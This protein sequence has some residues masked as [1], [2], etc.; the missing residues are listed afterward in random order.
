MIINILLLF[1]CV[2]AIYVGEEDCEDSCILDE[3][4]DYGY[5][6]ST[7]ITITQNFILSGVCF[8]TCFKSVNTIIFQPP[9]TPKPYTI[10]FYGMT[11]FPENIRNGMLKF[12]DNVNVKFNLYGDST[13]EMP[14]FEDV[15]NLRIGHNVSLTLFNSRWTSSKVKERYELHKPLT[16]NNNLTLTIPLLNQSNDAFITMTN[17]TLIFGVFDFMSIDNYFGDGSKLYS[18]FESGTNYLNVTRDLYIDTSTEI[19]GTEQKSLIVYLTSISSTTLIGSVKMIVNQVILA[20]ADLLLSDAAYIETNLFL[21]KDDDGTVY[22]KNT[23]QIYTG[24]Y[25]LVKDS[26]DMSSSFIIADTSELRLLC[27]SVGCQNFISNSKVS[28]KNNGII[29]INTDIT[30]DSQS[31]IIMTQ[32]SKIMKFQTTNNV[33]IAISG[34]LTMN[35]KSKILDCD[36]SSRD[37]SNLVLNQESSIIGNEFGNYYGTVVMNKAASIRVDTFVHAG[38]LEMNENSQFIT[39]NM[40]LMAIKENTT[41]FII[42]D[43]AAVLCNQHLNDTYVTKKVVFTV[44]NRE[45]SETPVFSFAYPSAINLSIFL[46]LKASGEFDYVSMKSLINGS[47][48][49]KRFV[50]LSDKKL[51]RFGSNQNVE[52][53]FEGNSLNEVTVYNNPHCP[54]TDKKCVLIPKQKINDLT[55]EFSFNGIIK[56]NPISLTVLTVEPVDVTISN[57]IRI[58]SSYTKSPSDTLIGFQMDDTSIN[59]LGNNLYTIQLLDETKVPKIMIIN[60]MEGEYFISS[61]GAF[62]IQ[63]T[64][65]S[66]SLSYIKNGTITNLKRGIVVCKYGYYDQTTNTCTNCQDTNCLQCTSKEN[67]QCVLCNEGYMLKNGNCV[68]KPSCCEYSTRNLCYIPT[69]GNQIILNGKCSVFGD[70]NCERAILDECEMCVKTNETDYFQNKN[71]KTCEEPENSNLSS[72]TKILSCDTNYYL[73]NQK[74]V[75]CSE[76]YSNCDICDLNNCQQCSSNYNLFNGSCIE[77]LCAE[78]D[79]NGLCIADDENCLP[80]MFLNN[81]CI[82]CKP[83]F[84]PN[85]YGKCSSSI[86]NCT[87]PSVYGCLRCSSGYFQDDNFQCQKCDETCQTCDKKSSKCVTCHSGYYLK[88]NVCLEVTG[89]KDVLNSGTGCASCYD[90]SYRS[91]LECFPCI[92]SCS[93]CQSKSICYTCKDDYYMTIDNL[94]QLKSSIEGCF[95]NVTSFGCSECQDGYYT[96]RERDC[97]KCAESCLTCDNKNGCTSCP[98][99]FILKNSE[100]VSMDNINNCIE[101]ENSMCSQCSGWYLPSEDGMYCIYTIPLWFIIVMVLLSIFI[102]ICIV[103]VTYFIVQKTIKLVYRNRQKST[104]CIFKMKYSNVNFVNSSDKRVLLSKNELFRDNDNLFKVN[105]EYKDVLCVGNNTKRPLKT[106]I[107]TKSNSTKYSIRANPSVV[108]LKRGEACEFE[109][110]MTIMCTCTITDCIFIIANSFVDNIESQIEVQ[111]NI[112]SELSSRLDP[113]ELIED[114]LLGE[115]SFGVVYKGK[116]R[117]NDVAIKMMKNGTKH[118]EEQ[119]KEFEKEVEMLDKF[120]SDYIV[121]FHGA[122]FIPNKMC[123]VTEFANYGSLSDLMKKKVSNEVTIKLRLKMMTDGAK[124]ILYLHTNGI[125]HRDIKPDNILVFSLND[126]D[127]VIAKLTDFGSS[128]NI[129]LLMTNMTFTKGI[130]TPTYMAPEV[131]K[132]EKYTK[133]A[134]IYSLGVT[135]Y[136]VLSWSE[137][138][139]SSKFKFPWKIAEF[140]VQGNRREKPENISGNL[141]KLIT[142]CWKQ[143]P[144]ERI[145]ISQLLSSELLL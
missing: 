102:L 80:K 86:E 27:R 136:E 7:E 21:N 135:L 123:M 61:T 3:E 81:R 118:D 45:P 88:N 106:Q 5:S 76:T 119:L 128:R 78:K 114:K 37:G 92:S 59:F 40:T 8:T 57:F 131:L 130:G 12:L 2:N 70:K 11:E 16:L 42:K 91:G 139:P 33:K 39:Q 46:N 87:H 124:G 14:H 99:S 121:H 90:G 56:V 15:K 23:I 145:T 125:L 41:Q 110:F 105:F 58:S 117:G 55:L 49:D 107:T 63:N 89:C 50:L 108:T 116:F 6:T 111:L 67:N 103:F 52:C 120:R 73:T 35:D 54:C 62:I 24:S 36:V 20:D 143:N 13:E 134:D 98:T 100:C 64:Q 104:Y 18:Y 144:Q 82:Q 142:L 34:N 65:T 127:C 140:V 96:Y 138:Y 109:I 79:Q 38:I 141:F 4:E 44:E 53:V 94:C 68:E 133:S 60:T 101:T 69:R 126:N 26:I 48:D 74:C 1:I 9:F 77:N 31:V 115:G 43:K 32:N 51:L 30:L 113:E 25:I 72:N 137:A 112:T 132:Q 75:K 66:S 84:Y 28:L 29:K 19:V 122:V 93:L 97:R 83:N 22:T 47:V 95:N 10:S 17:T 85:S 71:I 129:N